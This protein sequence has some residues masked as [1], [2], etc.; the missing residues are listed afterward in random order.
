MKNQDLFKELE[1]YYLPGPL[2]T[3]DRK[4][5][6]ELVKEGVFVEKDF[7]WGTTPYKT[8]CDLVNCIKEKKKRFVVFGSSAGFMCFYWNSLYPEIPTVGLDIHPARVEFAQGLVKKYNVKNVEFKLES[9]FDFKLNGTDLLWQNNLCFES[10]VAD[11][12]TAKIV[13]QNPEIAI[14]SYRPISAE[15]KYVKREYL[16]VS[17]MEKQPFFIYEK[18]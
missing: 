11:A 8:F 5:T 16:P 7:T 13:E 12:F 17:W 1:N 18:V 15:R 2:K 4:V 9:A 6:E 3:K 10:Q 14:I